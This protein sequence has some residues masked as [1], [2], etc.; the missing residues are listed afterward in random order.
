MKLNSGDVIIF[1]TDTVYGIGAKISDSLAM[2]KIYE[3]KHRP[4]EKRLSVLCA[5]IDDIEKIAYVTDLAK[6]LI[7]E[8]MPGGLTL[9]LNSREEVRSEYIFETIAVRIPKHE[10]AI[11]ILTENGPMA[12]TSV[13][14]SGK[15][16]MNDYIEIVKHFGDEVLYV[17]PNTLV[18]SKVSSTIV[19]LTSDE[20]V[21]IREGKLKFT[22]ITN[23]LNNN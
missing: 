15:A 14:T 19:D 10:L 9:I 22:E 1:P 17:Y 11:R 23:F 13:N 7:K 20:V 12:T 18:S 3:I 8:Y 2:D 16:P 5:N 4:K 6:R 21:L